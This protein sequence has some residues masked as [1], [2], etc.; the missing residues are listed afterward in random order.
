MKYV[1]VFLI[2]VTAL[3][4]ASSALAAMP[5]CNMDKSETEVSASQAA[6]PC[7]DNGDPADSQNSPDACN[8]VCAMAA[9]LL[10]DVTQPLTERVQPPL[11]TG[12]AQLRFVTYLF[13]NPPK[14]FS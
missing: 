7:H 11:P 9:A 13:E 2:C 4:F 6:M 1:R 5:C 10:S 8:C 12:K 3:C 14:I